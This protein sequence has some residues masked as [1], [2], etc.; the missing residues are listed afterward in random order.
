MEDRGGNI[1]DFPIKVEFIVREAS[2]Q[3]LTHL[4]RW[5][6][7]SRR[8]SGQDLSGDLIWGSQRGLPGGH[9]AHGPHQ[10]QLSPPRGED[11]SSGLC[12]LGQAG[13]SCP[14]LAVAGGAGG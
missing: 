7:S 10:G 13:A 1:I 8:Q 14:G 12:V 6:P 4:R 5:A 11:P 2:W 9:Q 3:V